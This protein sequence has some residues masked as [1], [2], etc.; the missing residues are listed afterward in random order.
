MKSLGYIVLT[1]FF[2]GF[3]TNVNAA[4]IIID[5]TDCA[6]INDC[7]SI[8]TT[9]RTS[10]TQ[11]IININ[12]NFGAT[13]TLS[14]LYKNDHEDGEEDGALADDWYETVYSGE[15]PNDAT[16]SWDGAPDP[17]ISCGEC[18][19]YVKAGLTAYMFNLGT[20]A[21]LAVWDGIG[22]LILQNFDDHAISHVTIYGA[23]SAVP[24]PAAA[25]LFGSALLG[26]V[27][28]SRRKSA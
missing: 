23:P 12:A 9:D 17:S 14:L 26:F 11:E 1:V 7:E 8:T 27:S 19:L 4:S 28:L 21:Y 15:D 24:L 13:G 10:P 6:S 18:F 5:P 22:D 20:D 16:I 2:W 25:W 3:T